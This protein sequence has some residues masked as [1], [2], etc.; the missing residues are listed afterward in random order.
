MGFSGM[1]AAILVVVLIGLVLGVTKLN[2]P[3][4]LVPVGLLVTAGI[5]KGVEKKV[6]A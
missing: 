6:S 1:R 3:G 2:L 5:L 4:W